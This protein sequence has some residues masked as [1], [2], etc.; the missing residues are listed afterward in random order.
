[1][2]IIA[3]D[4]AQKHSFIPERE[5]EESAPTKFFFTAMTEGEKVNFVSMGISEGKQ[6]SIPQGFFVDLVK[7]HLT[8]WENFN[9]KGGNPI[10]FSRTHIERIPWEIQIE[11]GMEIFN[12]SGLTE[13]EEKN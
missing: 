3:V 9:D 10:K 5:K 12:T 2:A 8:G 13:K 11:I 1:M 4:P 7:D 6:A